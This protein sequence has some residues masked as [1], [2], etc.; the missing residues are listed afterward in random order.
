MKLHIRDIGWTVLLLGLA[1]LGLFLVQF[2]QQCFYVR[3]GHEQAKAICDKAASL[4]EL[5]VD[6][7]S[8]N[9]L[10]RI[11]LSV[12][13]YEQYAVFE[14]P[15]TKHKIIVYRESIV[16][17]FPRSSGD[18]PGVIKLYDGNEN[19]LKEKQLE[20]VQ[21]ADTVCWTTNSVNIKLIVEW[22]F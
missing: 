13:E 1:L 19:C 10:D 15:L 3:R 9:R 2:I 22:F 14:S 8:S 18:A 6:V 21:L 16:A 4:T 12:P 11:P 20:M 17:G 5:D 7:P